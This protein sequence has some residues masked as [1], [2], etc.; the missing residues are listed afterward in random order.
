MKFGRWSWGYIPVALVLG[1]IWYEFWQS[2]AFTPPPR[3]EEPP[4]TQVAIAP[5]P[6]V[7]VPE[8]RPTVPIRPL[9]ETMPKPKPNPVLDDAFLKN[10][11]PI[12]LSVS[13]ASLDATVEALRKALG[14][15]T[16]IGVQNPNNNPDRTF[17]VNLKNVPFWDAFKALNAQVPIDLIPGYNSNQDGL[18]LNGNGNGVYRFQ[19]NGPAILYPLSIA[20]NRQSTGQANAGEQSPPRY[21]LR[22]GAAVDPRIRVT[23]YAPVEV[24]EAVDDTGRT[25]MGPANSGSYSAQATNYWETTV[26]FNAVEPRA[27]RATFKCQVR[28]VAQLSEATATLDDAPQKV[29]QSFTLGDRVMRLAQCDVQGSQMRLQVTLDVPQTQVPVAFTVVD[30]N[31]RSLTQQ[32]QTGTT[33]A[34]S[35]DNMS[36]PYRLVFRAPDQTRDMALAFELKDIPLP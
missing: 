14:A 6:V 3:R 30:A 21:D 25:L 1:I 8:S 31:G 35:L 36:P 32:T 17:T 26:N 29:G 2:G 10:P 22:V 19:T 18:I 15:G 23:R 9:P 24:L 4:D 28:F 27:K 7:P 20:Y 34:L 13:N 11:P 16:S 5:M 12:S 33:R